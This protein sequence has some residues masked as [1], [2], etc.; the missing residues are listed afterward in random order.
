MSIEGRE[1]HLMRDAKRC[2]PEVVLWNRL[3]FLP[4]G[5]AQFGVDLGGGDRNVQDDAASDERFNLGEVL[6]RLP[7]IEGTV[8]QL[9]TTGAGRRCSVTLESS[10]A[11][12]FAAK[13]SIATLVS[14]ATRSPLFGVDALELTVDD[15]PQFLRVLERERAGHFRERSHLVLHVHGQRDLVMLDKAPGTAERPEGVFSNTAGMVSLMTTLL[16]GHESRDGIRRVVL[17][18]RR[19]SGSDWHH[20]GFGMDPRGHGQNPRGINKPVFDEAKIGAKSGHRADQRTR[21][22][23]GLA[24]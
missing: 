7:R 18:R 15:L 9:A 24:K 19:P 10:R 17:Q 14:T 4:Q 8:A 6:G 11:S 16:A 12:A 2:D 13:T 23:T 22:P 1:R 21:E 20:R 3:A 5:E